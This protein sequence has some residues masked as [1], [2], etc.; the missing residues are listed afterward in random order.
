MNVLIVFVKFPEPGKVK[1][2]IAKNL[3]S[4]KAA[5]IYSRMA[6]GVVEKVSGSGA[7]RTVIYFDPPDREKD[8]RAWLGAD[9]AYFEPQ[10][11][12][13]I[14]DRMSDAFERVFRGGSL[15]AVLIG[16]DVPEINAENVSAAFGVLDDAD[17][18]LGP[19]QDGGYYLVGLR[20]FEPILFKGIDWNSNSV[21]IQTLDRIREAHLSYNL[22]DTLK[23][24]DTSEDVG[25]E[26]LTLLGME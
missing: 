16:T 21:H 25:P 10:S 9:G 12:G 19:A 1:T 20:R 26:L 23:D 11:S 22:L 3:G 8:I 18:V 13:T 17:A 6:K 14:G 24:I 15:K 7:Y 5:E 4:E 2:R